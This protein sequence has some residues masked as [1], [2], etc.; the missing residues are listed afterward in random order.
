MEFHKIVTQITNSLSWN[1]HILIFCLLSN[2]SLLFNAYWTSLLNFLAIKERKN[3]ASDHLNPLWSDST[4]WQYL[5][6]PG[7]YRIDPLYV[8]RKH[9]FF[10]LKWKKKKKNLPKS[11]ISLYIM[12][13]FVAPSSKCSPA[14]ALNSA[15]LMKNS[16]FNN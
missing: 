4:I 16:K 7:T 9:N 2:I 13:L 15:T 10:K 11:K 1:K 6:V 3:R 14:W 8:S 12:D 5:W